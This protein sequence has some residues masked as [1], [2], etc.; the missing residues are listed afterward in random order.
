MIYIV[1]IFIRK[2]LDAIRKST[3]DTNN[4]NNINSTNNTTDTNALPQQIPNDFIIPI[5]SVNDTNNIPIEN[6][7]EEKRL[8]E[9]I[10]PDLQHTTQILRF[11]IRI[12]IL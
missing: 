11:V 1:Y 4:I 5:P 9:K 3:N 7:N 6:I 8:L 10:L 12:F 2:D